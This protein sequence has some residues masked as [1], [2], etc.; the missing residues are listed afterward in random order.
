MRLGKS[1]MEGAGGRSEEGYVRGVKENSERLLRTFRNPAKVSLTMWEGR[2]Q[3]Y[4]GANERLV[5][6]SKLLR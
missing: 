2:N 4:Y 3:H 6:P 5:T 1:S